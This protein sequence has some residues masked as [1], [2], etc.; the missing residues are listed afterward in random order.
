MSGRFGALQRWLL[1]AWLIP[2]VGYPLGCVV[3]A[4]VKLS[5]SAQKREPLK[6]YSN[7]DYFRYL[8]KA[9]E[10]GLEKVSAAINYLLLV[11]GGVL[12]FIIKTLMEYRS[13]RA[14]AGA[15]K[16]GRLRRAQ[17]LLFLHAG[18]SCFF[19]LTFGVAAYLSLPDI[20]FVE[21]YD[22]TGELG[23]F[24]LAQIFG[25]LFAVL[26]LLVALGW[27]IRDLLP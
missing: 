18:V 22:V 14:K 27:M 1:I 13:N 9:P 11:T 5:S 20:A 15:A 24:V 23:R 25:L 3:P 10:F 12:A 17:L 21:S 7:Q 8:E 19:S 6:V 4:R 16:S 26:L 2:F